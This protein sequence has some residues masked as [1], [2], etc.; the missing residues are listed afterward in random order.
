MIILIFFLLAYVP[1]LCK[2]CICCF[3]DLFSSFLLAFHSHN[4]S[5]PDWHHSSPGGSL[6]G[7]V[8][9]VLWGK[10]C[11]REPTSLPDSPPE[12]QDFLLFIFNQLVITILH[13]EFQKWQS[14]YS[15][16]STQIDPLARSYLYFCRELYIFTPV[17]EIKICF[18]ALLYLPRSTFKF[19][20]VLKLLIKLEDPS[21]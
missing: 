6:L 20:Q 12:T 5:S 11:P 13:R 1:A 18:K 16:H 4:T 21:E 15:S 7:S 10:W 14:R 3:L 17:V 9:S 19:S 8:Q 2:I